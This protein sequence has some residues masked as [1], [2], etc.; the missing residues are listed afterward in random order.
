MNWTQEQYDAFNAKKG[1]LPSK[2]PVI[3]TKKSGKTGN[4]A[5][6]PEMLIIGIDPDIYKNG[7]CTWDR[8]NK[9]VELQTLTFFQLFEYLQE[10][11]D[12]IK[13]VK[14][15][16]GWKNK[17]S[18]F[19]E[20]K[21]IETASRIGKNVGAN[22]ETGKKIVEMCQHLRIPFREIKPLKKIWKSKDG[23][24]SHEELQKQIRFRGLPELTARTNQEQRDA[25]LISFNG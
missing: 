4:S 18:N 24:I 12:H 6:I 7:V 22:H 8:Q 15:E 3:P 16:A 17:K 20:A 1:Q 14:I 2:I 5:M 25:A 13:L 11:K 10:M 23:K 19:H 21:N 9:T